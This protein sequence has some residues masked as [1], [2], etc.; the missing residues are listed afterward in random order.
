MEKTEREI[1]RADEAAS[2]LKISRWSLYQKVRRREIPAYQQMQR[3]RL[4]FFKDELINYIEGMRLRTVKEL[5]A[6]AKTFNTN[7]I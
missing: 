5:E 7:T 2:L 1:L 3:G 4:F 6:A